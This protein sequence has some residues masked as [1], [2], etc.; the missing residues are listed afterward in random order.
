LKLPA[1]KISAATTRVRS[2]LEA[3]IAQ[4][5]SLHRL[6][7][8]QPDEPDVAAIELLCTGPSPY[9]LVRVPIPDRKGIVFA[10][11]LPGSR[12][13]YTQSEVVALVRFGIDRVVCLVPT[14]AIENL[15]GAYRY[16]ATVRSLFPGRFHQL[17]IPDHDIPPDDLAFETLVARIDD[18]V[19]TGD[20]VLV[21]CVGGCGRTGM[22]T[23][24]LMVRTGMGPEEAIRS[25][26]RHRRCGPETAEQVAY[27]LR[28]AQR[29]AESMCRSPLERPVQRVSFSRDAEG[30][31][32]LLARGG[33]GSVFAGRIHFRCGGSR[34]VA[35]KRFH[36][37]LRLRDVEM[38]SH[39]IAA[40]RRAGVG[41]PRML[42]ARLCDGS[43]AQ[44]SPLFG[45]LAQGSKLCQ[46][47]QFY[48]TLEI[49]ERCFA[50]EQLTCV[51]NAG[52]LP[53][54]DLFVVFRDR[55]KGI[56][57]LDLDLVEPDED[58][59]ESVRR[60]VRAIIQVGR[61]GDER[62]RLLAVA[63]SIASKTTRRRIDHV[64]RGAGNPFRA[65]WGLE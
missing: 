41:L 39:R 63:T 62:D 49:D 47:G 52:Y 3:L 32:R 15:H 50:I 51:A 59:G 55:A 17:E 29:N 45:S 54:I 25:F 26:R 36:Q 4:R 37:T 18:A 64:L 56:L 34:R 48:K 44:V 11:R 35:I 21:H 53:S 31:P 8:R 23:A 7:E 46:P 30:R 14:E 19:T 58:T 42:M 10:S 5:P 6:V 33:L 38:H 40:L 20:R 24:C 60:L 2:E 28:Y 16:L 61:T 65:L 27:V 13:T 12:P 1:E 57:P 22:F 43:W 9:Y